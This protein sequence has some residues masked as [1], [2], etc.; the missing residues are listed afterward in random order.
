M[1][2]MAAVTAGDDY[3]LLF[4]APADLKLSQPGLARITPI[5]RFLPGQGLTLKDK[6]GP[7]PLPPRLGYEHDAP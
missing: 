4:A 7:V 3:E 5:G 6:S 1:D 2:V